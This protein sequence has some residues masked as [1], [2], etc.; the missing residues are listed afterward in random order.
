MRIYG[1]DAKLYNAVRLDDFRNANL[2]E[3]LLA[4]DQSGEVSWKD[5]TGNTKS[6]TL[7]AHAIRI[8]RK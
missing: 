8:I 5:S 3:L 1:D 6:L 4:D 2:G 7:G